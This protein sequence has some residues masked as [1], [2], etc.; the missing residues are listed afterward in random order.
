MFTYILC[1][2]ICAAIWLIN[3]I[4]IIRAV[5]EHVISEVY[6]HSGLSAFFTLLTVELILGTRIWTEFD[7]S[8]LRIVGFILYVPSA[9]LVF[10]SMIELKRKGKP[11]TG[12]PT[13]ATV[14]I[15][16]G[17]Y[18]MVRQPMTLGMAIWSVALILV[19]QS[20]ISIILGVSSAFCFRMAASKE[21]EYNIRKFGDKY[22][23]YMKR[24]PMWNVLGRLRKGA[25]SN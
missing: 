11:Q 22:I 23:E 14:F 17:V 21:A 9:V 19:S 2:G 18:R 1:A 16:S 10:G 4:W 24:V 3:G 5:K 12:D 8:W 13:A 6:M 7:I 15:N 25:P 20:I